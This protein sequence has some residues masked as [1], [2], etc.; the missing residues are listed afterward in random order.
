MTKIA[1][2]SRY[3]RNTSGGYDYYLTKHNFDMLNNEGIEIVQV[4]STNN[5]DNIVNNCDALIIPGGADINPSLYKEEVNGTKEYYDF[6]D[7]LD[8]AYIDAFFNA[9]KPIIGI[10]R[11]HQIINV[12]F[13]GT[14]YQDIQNHRHTNHNVNI[15]KDSFIYD[16]YKTNN[17]TVNSLHHQAIKDL[18]PNFEIIA[19][20]DDGYIEACKYKNIYTVQWHPEMYDAHRFISYFLENIINKN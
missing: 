3:K 15:T 19:Q 17:L 5:I 2:T 6:I 18:A 9:N 4:N 10:C 16:I 12:F 7:T 13:G 8:Y 1:I 20:S 11:G 14:L